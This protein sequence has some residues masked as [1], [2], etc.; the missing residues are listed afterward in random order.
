MPSPARNIVRSRLRCSPRWWARRPSGS[1]CSPWSSPSSRSAA[2]RG[3]WR[4]GALGRRPARRA[5]GVGAV[6]ARGARAV[7][8][9]VRLLGAAGP[10]RQPRELRLAGRD[11]PARS[12]RTT[13]SR[14]PGGPSR[15]RPEGHHGVHPPRPGPDGRGGAPGGGDLRRGRRAPA[16]A[17]RGGGEARLRG[18]AGRDAR[19]RSRRRHRPRAGPGRGRH[20]PLRAAAL[21]RPGRAGVRRQLRRD[22]LPGHDRERRAGG[23]PAARGARA[24]SR[25]SPFP[26]W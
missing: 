25:S 2:A 16:G 19:H 18:A 3:R 26:R 12:R 21:R 23:R 24:T 5:G 17:R 20:D 13:W 1:T 7:G 15:E 4:R 14:P 9:R 22:R 8:A 10:G 11:R 6:R